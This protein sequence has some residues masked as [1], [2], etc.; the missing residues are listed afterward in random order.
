[1]PGRSRTGCSSDRRG[2]LWLVTL[3]AASGLVPG[4]SA[5]A[6]FAEGV[7]AYDGGDLRAAYEEW[8]PLAEAGDNRARVA[9]AGLLES[10][11]PGV[12]RDMA[13][14]ARWYQRA[15]LDGDAIAQM[16]LGELYARGAGVP[17][18][19]VRALAWLSLAAAQGRRW[20]AR[21]HAALADRLTSEQRAAAAALAETW[22]RKN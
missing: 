8:L 17:R 5:F 1:M 15:A 9:L 18:D 11:A 20:A 10:G 6:G 2:V 4:Q 13:A 16:N 7:A 12:P 19:P 3:L 22:R 21:R 14:A